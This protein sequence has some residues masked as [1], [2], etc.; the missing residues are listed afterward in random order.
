MI[1][2]STWTSAYLDLFEAAGSGGTRGHAFAVGSLSQLDAVP[3]INADQVIIRFSDQVNVD[4]GDLTLTG[5]NVETYTFASFTTETGPA[6]DFQAVW[7]LTAPIATDKLRIRLDSS[8]GT[9]VDDLFDDQFDGEWIDT[10]STYPSGD[11]VPGGDFAFRFNVL[12]ADFDGTGVITLNPD[13]QTMLAGNGASIGA[14]NY[15]P[16]IDLDG[17]GTVTLNPDLQTGLGNNGSFLPAGEPSAPGSAGAGSS[18]LTGAA[19]PA[20]APV[21]TPDSET[22]P[23]K[24]VIAIPRR[25]DALPRHLDVARLGPEEATSEAQSV[26]VLDVLGRTRATSRGFQDL[27]D[28]DSVDF[29]DLLAEVGSIF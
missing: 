10:V 29:M 8:T 11:N 24:R 21:L 28:S 27:D 18:S 2:G 4:Q 5:V 17:N 26:R 25:S 9:G 22:S 6:G 7:T 16:L 19:D 13:L 14:G 12:P 1:S 20:T 15:S 23:L 3:W